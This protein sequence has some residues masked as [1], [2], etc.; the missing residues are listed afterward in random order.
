MNLIMKI[1]ALLLGRVELTIELRYVH[2]RDR[3]SS[4]LLALLFLLGLHLIIAD[5]PCCGDTGP[6]NA[7]LGVCYRQSRFL[8]ESNETDQKLE[9]FVVR[10]AEGL[11]G[12]RVV[13]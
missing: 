10:E 7:G 6:V 1:L 9:M 12:F 2:V 11:K 13:V 4:A 5:V 3:V 8:Q